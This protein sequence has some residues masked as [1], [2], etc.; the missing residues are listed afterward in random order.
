MDM[1][2]Q[3]IPVFSTGHPCLIPSLAG[4]K[5]S[6][7]QR[8]A[9]GLLFQ[10]VLGTLALGVRSQFRFYCVEEISRDKYEQ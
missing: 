3:V 10:F 1:R 2:K 7:P 4:L 6:P 8:R 9:M 5:R